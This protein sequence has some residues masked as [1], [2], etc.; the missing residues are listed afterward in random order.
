M[1]SNELLR[2]GDKGQHYREDDIMSSASGSDSDP[3]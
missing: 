3:T 2:S 1:N